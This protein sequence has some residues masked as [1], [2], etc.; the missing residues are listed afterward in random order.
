[1]LQKLI[2][3]LFI[4]LFISNQE[5]CLGTKTILTRFEEKTNKQFQPPLLQAC[6]ASLQQTR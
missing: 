5:L 6:V 1:M 2:I 3:F 4:Y